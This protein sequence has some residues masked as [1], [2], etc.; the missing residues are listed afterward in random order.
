MYEP[1][2]SLRMDKLD[3]A[4]NP[5]GNSLHLADVAVRGSE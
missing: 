4:G 3:V 2:T 1:Q 5:A